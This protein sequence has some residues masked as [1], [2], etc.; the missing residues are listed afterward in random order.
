MSYPQDYGLLISQRDGEDLMT[1]GKIPQEFGWLYALY[2]FVYGA[3][4]LVRDDNGR[5]GYVITSGWGIWEG[6]GLFTAI[7]LPFTDH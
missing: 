6:M 2:L 5:I 1:R 7:F 4:D 3:S